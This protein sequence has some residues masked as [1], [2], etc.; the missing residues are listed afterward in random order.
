MSDP[1][2]DANF[3]QVY[4][5]VTTPDEVVKPMAARIERS[6][7]RVEITMPGSV[8]PIA[9]AVLNLAGF[10]PAMNGRW[11][12]LI[13]RHSVSRSGWVTTLNCEGAS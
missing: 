13:V 10:R 11:K 8:E 9:G 5:W 4:G 3:R 2:P 6:K 1:A 7:K 12:I